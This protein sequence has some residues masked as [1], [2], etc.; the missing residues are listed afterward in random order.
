MQEFLGEGTIYFVSHC[1]FSSLSW[2]CFLLWQQN[3]P[4]VGKYHV[5]YLTGSPEPKQVLSFIFAPQKNPS[6]W[7]VEI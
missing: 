6:I 2:R 4:W 1:I 3:S 5:W 7:E